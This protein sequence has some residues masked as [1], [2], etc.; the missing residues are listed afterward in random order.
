MCFFCL[1]NKTKQKKT[2]TSKTRISEI[3]C[4]INEEN[5]KY[6]ERT[7]NKDIA[8]IITSLIIF[9][10]NDK[11]L[12]STRLDTVE[13]AKRIKIFIIEITPIHLSTYAVPFFTFIISC[14]LLFVNKKLRTQ[15]RFQRI[16]IRCRE[17]VY[18]SAHERKNI[19][20]ISHPIK[21]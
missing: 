11:H 15:H 16:H 14:L 17:K 4:D 19:A 1:K 5:K 7:S 3:I 20:Y 2:D 12:L 21:M 8:T 13:I 6:A 10:F 18:L 9:D